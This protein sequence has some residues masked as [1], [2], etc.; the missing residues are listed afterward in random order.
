MATTIRLSDYDRTI[1]LDALGVYAIALENDGDDDA[2]RQA[3][4]VQHFIREEI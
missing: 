1:I 4:L 2:A 3:R